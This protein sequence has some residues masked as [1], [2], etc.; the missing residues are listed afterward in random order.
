MF[1]NWVVKTFIHLSGPKE[2]WEADLIALE[3]IPRENRNLFVVG[4]F[5]IVSGFLKIPHTNNEEFGFMYIYIYIYIHT[6]N[7]NNHI[8]IYTHYI[9]ILIGL[10][11]VSSL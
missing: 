4:W 1:F 3:R 2:N 5:V 8:Y 11:P 9:V 10:C 6:Y 7:I